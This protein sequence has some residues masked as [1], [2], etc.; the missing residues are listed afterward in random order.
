MKEKIISISKIISSNIKRYQSI[1]DI[2]NS[3]TLEQTELFPI[4]NT[5]YKKK[6]KL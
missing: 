3:V 5:Q 6:N 2:I 4:I 1:T